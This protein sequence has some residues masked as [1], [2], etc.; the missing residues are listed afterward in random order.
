M[1]LSHPRSLTALV[2]AALLVASLGTIVPAASATPAEV[3]DPRVAKVA[4]VL[5]SGAMPAGVYSL[6][7]LA[8]D[9][10]DTPATAV[11][12]DGTAMG[13]VDE[14]GDRIDVYS[15][16]LT[17]GDRLGVR[18]TGDT[19]LDADAYLYAPGTTSL[20]GTPALAG[21]IGDAFGK[22][23]VYYVETSGTYYIAVTPATGAGEYTLTAY[24]TPW[25][26][27]ADN[28]IEGVAIPASPFAGS[29]KED[30]D[31]DDLY[32]VELAGGDRFTVTVEAG[33][34][35]DADVLLY[36]PVTGT[37]VT[38]VPV[39]GSAGVGVAG[40][41][42]FVFDIP[43]S[44][45]VAD[46]YLDVRVRTG[47]GDYDVTWSVT[48]LPEG[49]WDDEADALP[50][51]LGD[52]TGSLDVLTDANDLYSVGIAAGQ[53]LS[54]DM[55][56]AVASDFDI[57]VYGPGAT[58]VLDTV[59]VVWSNDALSSE[60][61]I[62]DCSATGT[63][64]V[65]VRAFSG[66]GSYTLTAALA[67][68]PEFTAADRVFGANRYAT[69]LAVSAE[70]F[71]ADSVQT[72]VLATGQDFPDALSA[73]A[74]AG[75]LGSPMLLTPK[76]VLP[77]GLLAELD[78]LGATRV[79]IVGGE[80]V[81]GPGVVSALTNAGYTV[82][83][84]S[85][86][87]RFLTSAAVAR[88]VVEITGDRT[89]LTAFLVNGYDFADANAVSPYAYSQAF[90]VLLTGASSLHPTTAAVAEEIGVTHVVIAGG[91]SVVSDAVATQMRAV[92]GVM[93]THREGGL[94]RYETA[95]MVAGYAVD[96]FWADNSSVGIA[97]GLVF[98]DALGGGA[99]LGARGG[100]LL[101]TDA[102]TLSA[103]T[104]TYLQDAA[105]DVLEVQIFGGTGAVSDT[106]KSAI[107][108]ALTVG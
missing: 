16:A 73:S 103:A 64:Y 95:A 7:V 32:A 51:T 12:I 1:A 81:V 65:E 14:N 96:M 67:A 90:P 62:F 83:R 22:S 43:G 85:G 13:A 82:K 9:A 34:G 15:I 40:T 75:A 58:N 66:S 76:D 17:A 27:D 60:S 2:V 35:L 44:A 6:S 71:A 38:G 52:R 39:A 47:T 78:R 25:A 31:P 91:R 97:T 74:L 8:E 93:T 59:P 54:L 108:K 102:V 89:A 20:V 5:A 26:D 106:V 57:Y 19:T 29:L 36:D 55:L 70:T 68:T 101:M 21:T 11:P 49:A 33:A 41:E 37:I 24:A 72:A 63:Y 3:F 50:L 28:D 100:V 23:F 18:V 4:D 77:T 30:V 10:D 98:A 46:Y 99:A 107:N 88:R 94:N 56:G 79:E 69:A 92:D 45:V 105:E 80:G 61:L 84:T 42:T 87:D 53:S 86:N 48:D 104:Q